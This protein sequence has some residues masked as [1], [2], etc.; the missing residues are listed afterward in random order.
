MMENMAA[1]WPGIKQD[2]LKWPDFEDGVSVLVEFKGER[3]GKRYLLEAYLNPILRK[4]SGS[5]YCMELPD[6]V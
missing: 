3:V 4:E 5:S 1:M 2:N 6:F